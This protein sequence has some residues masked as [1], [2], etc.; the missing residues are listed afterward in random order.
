MDE[1]DRIIGY[2]Q[3]KNELRRIC[4]ILVNP[5]KYEKFGV[6]ASQGLLLHGIPGVGKTLMAECFIKES[7][8]KCFLC[9]KNK[10]DGSFVRE[11][12]K[13]F[14]EAKANQPSIVFLDDMD[15]FSNEDSFHSDTDEFVTIQTC[16][17]E[18][19]DS[20]V[21]VVATANDIRELPRSLRRDGR[22][23]TIIPVD[24]ATGEDSE[25]IIE[26]YLN[27]KKNLG[28]INV[29]EFAKIMSCMSCAK[30]ETIINE[31]GA[32]A[33]YNGKDKIG[34]EELLKAYLRKTFEAPSD[35]SGADI[36]DEDRK[37][38]AYHEAGHVVVG[39]V[40]KKESIAL[41]S[42]A[43]HRG[44]V[45]GITV[46]NNSEPM[47]NIKEKERINSICKI[48]GGKAAI[49]VV[50]GEIDTGANDDLHKAFDRA[51]EL[52]D[53]FCGFGFDKFLEGPNTDSNEKKERLCMAVS[54]ELKELYRRTKKLLM[55]N[56]EFLDK[57]A[58]ALMEKTTLVMGDIQEIRNSCKI[59][60]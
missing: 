47:R 36:K 51:T 37:Y 17:D 48:L 20:D 40:L 60:N 27:Q 26:Y 9:R 56:I 22:F 55:D 13:V 54:N 53:D 8:R 35:E 59:I 18:L 45:G 2:D 15:K 11:I 33:A 49:E 24:Y 30:I 58:K 34:K 19:K 41:A 50:F 29:K 16:I 39:E 38:V 5:K 42:I 10:A 57:M 46:N 28:D 44:T 12:T 32:Y 23:S 7:K 25:K 1:F 14:E 3:I 43:N 52:M 31:A 4:D 21:F 6:K